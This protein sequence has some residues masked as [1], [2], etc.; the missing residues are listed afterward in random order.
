MINTTRSRVHAPARQTPD[1]LFVG[2]VDLNDELDWNACGLHCIRLGNGTRKTVKE[3]TLPA[4]WLRNARF[5]QIDDDVIRNKSAFI[6]DL[7]G[8]HTQVGTGLDR[9]AQHIP[10]GNLWNAETLLDE[11]GL[12][13]FSRPRAT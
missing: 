3:K 12:C 5:D 11:I 4:V 9:S 13:P 7:L 1:N 10:S 6:H 8:H 2:H